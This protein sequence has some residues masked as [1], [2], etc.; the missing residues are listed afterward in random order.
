MIVYALLL[1]LSRYPF[2][3]LPARRYGRPL[4]TTA[5]RA[6]LVTAS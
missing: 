5:L 2:A 4:R 3:V 1:L 6:W